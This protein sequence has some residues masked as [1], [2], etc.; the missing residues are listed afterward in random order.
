MN[1]QRINPNE[2][3]KTPNLRTFEPLN[4][5]KMNK[6]KISVI[7]TLILVTSAAIYGYINVFS[8]NTKFDKNELYIFIPTGSTYEDVLK[9]V[10]PNVK[11]INKFKFVAEKRSYNSHVFPG[12]FLFKKGMNSFQ[13]ITAL[14]HNE[15]GIPSRTLGESIKQSI[16]AK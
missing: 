12:R 6:K 10:A 15:A 13:L 16:I 8:N 1:S 14:R 4:L 11:D 9:I 5:K 2:K 3:N 7:I